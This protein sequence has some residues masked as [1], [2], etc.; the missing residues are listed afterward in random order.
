MEG[1]FP[2]L[3]FLDTD[4]ISSLG[5]VFFNTFLLR[6]LQCFC[7]LLPAQGTELMVGSSHTLSGAYTLLQPQGI[8]QQK[9]ASSF[10]NE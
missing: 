1:L 3:F 9:L 7:R 5:Q 4:C 8:V 2:L 10:Q 6:E